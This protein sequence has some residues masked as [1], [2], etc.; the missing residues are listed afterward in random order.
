MTEVSPILPPTF[1]QTKGQEKLRVLKR[2]VA[3]VTASKGAA[4]LTN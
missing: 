2:G 4:N 1:P 3:A